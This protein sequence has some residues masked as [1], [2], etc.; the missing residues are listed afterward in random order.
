MV[1]AIGPLLLAAM[2]V[3]FGG[4]ARQGEETRKALAQSFVYQREIENLFSLI[5]DA[6]TGQRG[7]L[8]SGDRSFLVPY[9]EARQN[10][11]GQI[12]RVQDLAA[13]HAS[14]GEVRR[15]RQLIDAKFAEMQEL[16]ELRDQAGPVAAATQVKQ[17][18]GKRQMDAIRVAIVRIRGKAGAD[19]ATME[20]NQAAR[21]R[22]N[23]RIIWG[24]IAFIAVAACGLGVLIGRGRR[25]NNLLAMQR[26]ES[27]ARQQAIFDSV[28]DSIVLINPSGSIETINPAAER[29]FGYTTEQLLRRDISTLVD[30]AP[31]E[32]PFLERLG[33]RDGQLQK[34]ELIDLAGRDI[35]GEPVPVDVVLGTMVLPDGIH[36]IAA[37]RD[38][39][40]RKEIDRLKDDFISTV[41]HELRTPLTSVVGSLSL[42][43]SGAAGPLPADAQRL[44]EIAETNSQR[45]IRLINDILDIDQIRKGRMAFE[46]S[47]VDLR[48]VMSKAVQTMQGLADRRSIAIDVKAPISPI[49]ACA[50]ADRLIQVAG[51]LLSNAVKFSP[52]N[53]TVRLE[54]I[55]GGEDHVIQITDSGPGIPPEFA[56]TIF[57]RF[58]RGAQPSRQLIAGTGL[59]L[60]ISREIIRSHGGEISFEN[61]SEGGA[62]FAFSVPRDT[63]HASETS[64]FG[65]ARLL[66]CEDDADAGRTIQSIL[67]AHGYASDLVTTMRE[68]IAR[69]R[70]QPYAA[71]LLDMT[72][73][74]ADGA[75][76][77]RAITQDPSTGKPPIIVISGIAPPANTE[78]Q[79]F[80]GW[81]QKP[82][83][84]PRLVQLVQRAIR[85]QG[86][87]KAV[88]LHIEDDGD[89][90]EL[91]AAA[92][93]GRGLLLNATSLSSARAILAE[94]RPDALVLDLGLPDG[95]GLALLTEIKSWDKPL[96]IIVYS[97]QEMDEDTH[98]LA[99]AVMVKS[100]RALPKL[101]ST[102]LDIVDRHGG[103]R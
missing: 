69:A 20:R 85:R 15:L 35:D 10:M 40:G 70:S 34:T 44:A 56:K 23:R 54:L 31:G 59:G 94:R 49:M 12:S 13:R 17:G 86:Q 47:V 95:S 26:E 71:I 73:A 103:P 42:L 36:I 77:I 96:P 7:Y 24:A 99:D 90:R 97:A 68:A 101:A 58:A 61:R 48:V 92:L 53:T 28:T 9:D 4:Q 39:S 41:S 3:W 78:N 88:I 83:D 102:V 46:Y 89:T 1:A 27:A 38:A 22:H 72:L 74:D 51:N 2:A 33:Y 25:Q 91:F 21:I 62:R 29:M 14:G 76:V 84:P 63:T 98:R 37:L 75:D 82:F 43:R 19:V 93:A 55:E 57:N 18:I 60:A 45:L 32:G 5:K 66:I 65:L 50:D 30:I 52:E 16:I 8:L 81:L 6:E 67:T 87:N 11:G 64:E 100:R 79:A 80:A